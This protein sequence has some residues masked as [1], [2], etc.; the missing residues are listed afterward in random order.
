M[1]EILKLYGK[2]NYLF[3]DEFVKTSHTKM[4]K[5][6]YISL[7]KLAADDKYD[8]VIFLK[9]DVD[10]VGVSRKISSMYTKNVLNEQENFG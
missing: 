3:A 9:I 1:F 4:T 2:Q 8:S 6:F 7:Q 10:E 5:K